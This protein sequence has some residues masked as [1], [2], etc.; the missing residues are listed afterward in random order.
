MR[1]LIAV[2]AAA[3]VA[4][5]IA[6]TATAQASPV[7]KSASAA[8]AEYAPPPIVWRACDSTTLQAFGAECGMLTVPMD[9]AKPKGKKIQLAVSRV[10]HTTHNYKG[11]MLVNPGGPGASGLIFS[12]FQTFVPNGGGAPYDWIGFDPRGVGSSVP[13]LTCNPNYFHGDR[14]PYAPTT[15]R[16][17]KQWINR[18][19]AYAADCKDAASSELFKHVK[20]TDSVADMESLRIALGQQKINYYGFSYGTYLGSVYA[21]LHPTR[22]G[23]F[24]FDGT[25]NPYRVFYRSNLDQ[26]RA[27]QKTFDIYFTWLAKYNGIYHVGATQKAVRANYFKALRQLD[28][29]AAGGI[30]GGDELID[31]FTSAAYGVYYWGDIAQAFSDY[32]NK[33]DASAL[34]A[35]YVDANPTTTGADNVYAMYLATQ[36]TDAPWPKSQKKLDQDSFELVSQGYNYLTWSNAWFNGPC[37]YWKFHASRPVNVTGNKVRTPILMIGETY[38]AA[39]P[40]PGSLVVRKLFPT[41]SLIEGLGGSTHAGSLSGIACTDDTIAT[42]LLTG[43][44]PTRRSGDRSDKI[45]PPVPQ[46]TPTAPA[47]TTSAS[48]SS[49]GKT[50]VLDQL[51]ATIATFASHG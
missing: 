46:P 19:K 32:I 45:C 6:A 30:L 15:S 23:K 18:S 20:T 44:V 14:P 33:G 51:R 27:F 49:A 50:A 24:I 1:K 36:C 4:L 48:R 9:Y 40:F 26:D 37:A 7:K 3:I 38:D 34:T 2:L 35:R 39:T 16:I 12:V 42:Y 47:A 13:A 22:V 5:G 10:L 31:V 25:V 17:Y 28:H 43:K 21:T 11:V 41:A 29:K 8:A